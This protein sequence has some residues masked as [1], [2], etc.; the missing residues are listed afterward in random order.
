MLISLLF[1][2]TDFVLR[3]IGG[4]GCGLWVMGY[5]LWRWGRRVGLC[6]EERREV[7]VFWRRG[8]ECLDVNMHSSL[9]GPVGGSGRDTY[10]STRDALWSSIDTA[11]RLG[12]QTW[13]RE[14]DLYA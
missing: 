11:D 12:G 9:G 3:K 6:E 1:E 14:R 10:G 13:Q 5:G 4:N 8:M 7:R 2:V